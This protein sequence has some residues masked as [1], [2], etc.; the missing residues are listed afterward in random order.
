MPNEATLY[1]HGIIHTMRPGEDPAD[2]LLVRG[3]HIAAVGTR[4][5]LL[6]LAGAAD[7]VDLDGYTVIP[8]FNDCHAHLLPFGLTL[9]Q[10]DVSADSVHSIAEIAGAVEQRA[11]RTESREWI[12]GRGYNQNELVEARHITRLEL[13]RVSSGQPVVLDH[14]SGHVLVCNTAALERAGITRDTENPA[15][16]EIEHDEHG[17]PTGLLKEAAMDLLRRV[18]PT[19]T[20]L[21]GRD[22]ILKAMTTLSTF[23]ITSASDAW[24]GRGPSIESELD[25]Y[26]A[27][28]R[29]G[30]L[31]ARITLMPLISYVVGDDSD[32]VRVPSDFDV[33][34]DPAWLSIGATKIFSDGALSTRTAAMREPYADDPKNRG[35]LLWERAA[36]VAAMRRAHKAGWQIATHALGDRAVEMVL[37]C[38]AEA[39][40][41]CR[42]GDHRHR[43][44]HC[45]YADE[46]MARRIR[47]LG[48]VPSLQ[49]D[50]YRLGD[51]YVAALGLRRAEESIPTGLFRR[52]GVEI[53]ISS[54]L[55]VIPG[56]PLDVVRSA[57]ERRTPRGVQLGP[58]HAMAAMEAIRGYTWG[59]AHATHSERSKGVLAAGMLADFT[60]L[61]HDPARTALDDWQTIQ[62][63]QT[64]VAGQVMYQG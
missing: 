58:H 34:T 38:Y 10:L 19:P 56:R 15:G 12:H 35:I 46:T 50:I 40:I 17:N 30:R 7:R 63:V 26:R 57:M 1:S 43:I 23:G 2:S 53:A 37:D 11:R 27:A 62:V 3:D 21:E 45:M 59:G 48:I 39:M 61:S 28:A 25:M 13:D 60:V 47:D 41:D 20:E 16:G 9:D 54:D 8:G 52:L 18:I 32:P 6:A 64:V 49:P 33:G 44:E 42:R 29:S 4:D 51:A 24:T 22:A 36:L 55:P 5:D 31:T 14:T